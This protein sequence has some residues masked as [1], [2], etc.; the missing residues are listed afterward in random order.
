[1]LEV[2]H[3]NQSVVALAALDLQVAILSHEKQ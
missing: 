1:M 2:E 3:C